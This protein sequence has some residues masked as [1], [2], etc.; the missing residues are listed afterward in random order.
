MTH[1]AME[2]IF[3]DSQSRDR[4]VKFLEYQSAGVREYWVIDP[5]SQVVEAYS[6]GPDRAFQERSERSGARS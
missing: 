6:L 4:R 2:V 5:L 1:S 3:P